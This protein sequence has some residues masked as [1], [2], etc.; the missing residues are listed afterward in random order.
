[1]LATDAFLAGQPPWVGLGALVVAGAIASVINSMAGGG[2]LLTLPMLMAVGLP[3]GL[4]NG[5]NR[6]G[7]VVQG[8]AA[9]ITFHRRGVRDYGLV[10]RLLPAMMLGA[11][12]GSWLATRL[13]DDLLRVVFGVMLAGWAVFLV[14]RPGGFLNVP[15]Q[16]RKVGP[17]ALV[18]SVLIGVYG[19]FLQAGVGFPLLALLVPYLGYP[20]VRAN[21]I[22]VALV[23]GFSLVSLPVFVLAG[24]VQWREGLALAAG[25]MVGGWLG[26]RLQLRAGATLVRWVVV[27]AVAVSG[28]AMLRGALG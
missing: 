16:P 4:A 27:V 26:A 22:K 28:V 23:L 18:L 2:S 7:V 1:M 19:G 8:L 14:L 17:L 13:G 21:A 9:V 24:Q 12:G 6:V 3:A 15:E 10:A 20:A 5:T 25:G 11:A